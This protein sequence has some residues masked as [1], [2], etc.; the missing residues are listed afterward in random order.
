[1]ERLPSW[2]TRRMLA[3]VLIVL[4][5]DVSL[6]PQRLERNGGKGCSFLKCMCIGVRA[7]IPRQQHL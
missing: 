6:F 7:G 2:L 4:S 5:K 3:S 1:M